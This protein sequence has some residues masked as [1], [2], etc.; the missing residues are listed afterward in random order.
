MIPQAFNVL[1]H[2]KTSIYSSCTTNDEYTCM[3][4][5]LATNMELRNEVGTY[6]IFNN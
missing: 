3:M 2:D 4:N 5:K 1:E 6:I